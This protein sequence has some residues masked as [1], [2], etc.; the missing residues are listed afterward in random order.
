MY[1][2][3]IYKYTSPSGKIYIGQTSHEQSRRKDFLSDKNYAGPKIN[4]ARNK[5]GVENF[6]Y[7]IIFKVESLIESEVKE[8]LNDKEIQ[9]ITLFDSFEN[10]YNLDLGGGT[11]S[12]KRTEESNKN[13]S[14]S[15]TEY[16]KTH[17]SAVAKSILQYDIDGNFIQ[18][19]ESASKAAKFLNKEGC[20]ITNVCN[21]KRNQAFGYI[22][23][24]RSDFIE[25]P[26][27]IQIANTKSTILPVKQYTLDGVFIKQWDNLSLAAIDLGYSLGNFS[28]YCNGKNN[29]VYKGYKYYRGNPPDNLINDTQIPK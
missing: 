13:L 25:I 6:E 20:S 3:I 18:E 19:W 2:G 26:N 15:I 22:W 8:I 24:Y 28:T 23:K 10:G 21:G 11:A 5:Y 29:N 7:E 17:K 12:Y 4:S 16:Y 1:K 27:N 14:E 9:Y